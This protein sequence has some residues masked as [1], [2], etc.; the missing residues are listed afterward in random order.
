MESSLETA[1]ATELYGSDTEAPPQTE[2]PPASQDEVNVTSEEYCRRTIGPVEVVHEERVGRFV[3]AAGWE[4]FIHDDEGRPHQVLILNIPSG[5]DVSGLELEQASLEGY[6]S[7]VAVPEEGVVVMTVEDV[8]L[9]T[10]DL[11]TL[12]AINE[13]LRFGEPISKVFHRV[14]QRGRRRQ[15]V[16]KDD[17][18][19][20]VVRWAGVRRPVKPRP[21]KTKEELRTLITK[22]S[23][24]PQKDI[25]EKLQISSGTLARRLRESRAAA[26]LESQTELFCHALREGIIDPHEIEIDAVWDPD[27]NGEDL[28]LLRLLTPEIS[29]SELSEAFGPGTSSRLSRLVSRT[30]SCNRHELW[31]LC[32]QQGIVEFTPRA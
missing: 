11:A 27:I 28:R 20:P 19:R 23:W 21:R 30:G 25:S 15:P 2:T 4:R 12:L 6:R 24:R 3:E 16:W 9:Y 17:I 18:T 8:D 7:V 22:E 29:V 5:I 10:D 1:I 13:S 31:I 26:G 14:T 32:V